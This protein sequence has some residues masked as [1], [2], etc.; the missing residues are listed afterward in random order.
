MFFYNK[1]LF[2]KAKVD[3]PTFDW[4]W[5]KLREASKALTMDTN[6]DGKEDQWG[7]AFETWFVVWLH[8]IWSNGGD[9]FN[10]DQTKCAL[11]DPKATEAIQTWADMINVDKCAIP[12]SEASAM[13]GAGNAFKTGAVGMFMG[14]A[15][16]IAEMKAAREQGLDW[17][18]VLPPKAPTGNRS[19]YMHLECWAT[20]KASKVPNACWQYIRDFTANETAEFISYYPGIPLLKKDIGLFLTD[21]NKSYGWDKLPEIIEDPKNIRIPGAGSKFDKISQLV[22]A[23]LDL[24]FTGEKTAQAAAETVA[25][26]VDE[27]L[28]R[29]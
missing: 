10:A 20:A 7:V 25:P 2:D 3:Y 14:Y 27:E 23:E 4:D 19:F 12:V 13:Q 5:A 22:Q 6:G 24:V 1:T 17:G 11:T 26:Q 21:E 29:S 28:A 9:L 16:N 15:W 18:C 8:W